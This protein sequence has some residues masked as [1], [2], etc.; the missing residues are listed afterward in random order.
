[1]GM[2]LAEIPFNHV[3]QRHQYYDLR[4]AMIVQFTLRFQIFAQMITK[5]KL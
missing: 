1:M 4:Q 2:E 3:Y 5:Y